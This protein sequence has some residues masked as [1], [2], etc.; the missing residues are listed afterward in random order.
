[1][2][3]SCSNKCTV[4]KVGC[5][6]ILIGG[7]NWGLVGLGGFLGSDLNVVH[8]ILGAWPKVEWLVYLLVGVSTLCKAMKCCKCCK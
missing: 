4:C 3:D 5:I 8:M 1:M 7:I 6:L 2:G